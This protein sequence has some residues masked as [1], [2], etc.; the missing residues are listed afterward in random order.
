MGRGRFNEFEISYQ[1]TALTWVY[2]TTSYLTSPTIVHFPFLWTLR[3]DESP[4]I[5][6]STPSTIVSKNPTVGGAVLGV[7]VVKPLPLRNPPNSSRSI[8]CRSWVLHLVQRSISSGAHISSEDSFTVLFL[9]PDS[10]YRTDVLF[11]H[12]LSSILEPEGSALNLRT[13]VGGCRPVSPVVQLE[14]TQFKGV[15]FYP[16]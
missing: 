7:R 1:T 12:V 6:S 10:M 2:K 14:N 4:K 3:P 9:V 13:K 8:Q 16:F 11:S 5:T 15:T